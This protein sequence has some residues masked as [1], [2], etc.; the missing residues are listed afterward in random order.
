[1]VNVSLLGALWHDETLITV[2]GI[3]LLLTLCSC[4]F[5]SCKRRA[6]REHP[7]FFAKKSKLLDALAIRSEPTT[8]NLIA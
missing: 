5:S 8:N 3:H 6:M 1:M 7:I 4:L 2:R